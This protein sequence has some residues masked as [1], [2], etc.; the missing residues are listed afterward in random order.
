MRTCKGNLL[1]EAMMAVF[2]MGMLL[3]M[4]AVNSPKSFHGSPEET[5]VILL[6]LLNEEMRS[7]AES[8]NFS[9]IR[10]NEETLIHTNHNVVII[11]RSRIDEH[12]RIYYGSTYNPRFR[13]STS[14]KFEING[15]AAQSGSIYFYR[16]NKV[17]STIMIHVGTLAMHI[18]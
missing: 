15:K 12:V 7:A 3:V 13:S 6:G 5:P 18:R 11:K 14:F 8:M 4:T 10:V 17:E 1:F 16:N 2:L 9:Q